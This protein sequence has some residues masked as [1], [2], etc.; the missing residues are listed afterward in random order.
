MPSSH[1]CP[2][3]ASLMGY[4]DSATVLDRYAAEY[5]VCA[6]CGLVC[7]RETP[8]LEEAY[9]SAI[10]AADSGLLRR[11]RKLSGIASTVIRAEGL[12]GGRYLDWA[13]GYG[14]FTQTMRDKGFEFWQYDEYAEPLFAR[15]FRDDGT[16]SFDLITAFEV[17]EHLADPRAELAGLAERTDRILFSTELLPDPAPRVAEW[18]YYMPEVGQHITFHT[19][20]SLRILGEHLGYELTTNGANWH[21]FHRGRASA[22][23]R[24][25]LSPAFVHLGRSAR[26]QIA[27]L[28]AR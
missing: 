10:H 3:C 23:T 20:Q 21:L 12:H 11:A 25:L 9:A 27:R 5:Q 4:F 17:M 22:R 1:E 28:R 7:T 19:V 24:A 13:G 2:V 8:W 26:R 14:V 6:R 15:D 18:W 16:G